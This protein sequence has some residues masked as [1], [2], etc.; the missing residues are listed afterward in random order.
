MALINPQYHEFGYI[1]DVTGTK[2]AYDAPVDPGRRDY[3]TCYA[4]E[5]NS[6]DPSYR[7]YYSFDTSS[8][9]SYAIISSA[10]FSYYHHGTT[11]GI[12]GVGEGISFRIN[13]AIGHDFIGGSIDTSDWGGGMVGD[14]EKTL[15]DYPATP[16]SG[17]TNI[18]IDTS[19]I[20]KT[21]D[22]D[23]ELKESCIYSGGYSNTVLYDIWSHSTRGLKYA[24]MQVNYTLP[25]SSRF[26]LLGVN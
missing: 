14:N 17:V 10:Q 16:T 6:A 15:A 18:T 12:P 20:T 1:K 25:G 7:T 24:T 23:V 11:Y 8:I 13:A 9:P 2:T 3:G 5:T 19:H 4:S 22:T 26:M 21:G